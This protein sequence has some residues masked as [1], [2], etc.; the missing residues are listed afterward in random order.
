MYTHAAICW[1]FF[2]HMY[3][4]LHT[5]TV[6]CVLSDMYTVWLFFYHIFSEY[7]MS[8]LLCVLICVYMCIYIRFY[9]H[10][11]FMY[12]LPCILAHNFLRILKHS[13]TLTHSF[14]CWLFTVCVSCYALICIRL[15]LCLCLYAMTASVPVLSIFFTVYIS[16]NVL[17]WAN[18]T[19]CWQL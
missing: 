11:P 5:A 2:L 9:L 12:I 14:Q 3:I 1:Y 7:I 16:L 6:N 10:T 19:I 18:S 4:H 13:S 8:V 17:C 15:C